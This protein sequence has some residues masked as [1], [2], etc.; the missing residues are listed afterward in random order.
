VAVSG[1]EGDCPIEGWGVEPDIVVDH[2]PHATFEGADAQLATAVRELLKA[3]E[4]NLV[5][6]PKAP[7]YPRK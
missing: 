2:L 1:P 5:T 6:V 7:A 3:L 4:E